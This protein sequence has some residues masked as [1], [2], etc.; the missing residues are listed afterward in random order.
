MRT[1]TLQSASRADVLV[2]A[3]LITLSFIPLLAGAFRIVQ[4]GLGAEVTPQNARFFAAPAPVVLHI[5]SVTFYCLLGA[6]QFAP[7]LRRRRPDWH[8]AA[9]RL[10]IGFGL[11]SALS[12]LW[13]T[14]TYPYAPPDGFALYTIRQ[15]VGSA[16]LLSILLG[17]AAVRRRDFTQHGAWMMRGYA[18]GLG[19][20]TQVV[21]SVTWLLIVGKQDENARVLV[22]SAGW[23][24][25]IFVAE[26][27]IR[28]RPA[29]T[30][31]AAIAG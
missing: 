4:L 10:L 8:R 3:A 15:V 13:M 5:L 2:P 31:R 28:R 11:A 18:I 14:W 17:L 7:G 30:I 22:M 9:G 20:G 16:M 23:I 12:G 29:R 6:F 25:N 1:A 26:W 21:T 27:L 19:A 24:I